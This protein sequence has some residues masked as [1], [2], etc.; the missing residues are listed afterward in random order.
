MESP[1]LDIVT[2][3]ERCY[4]LL[5][6]HIVSISS[7]SLAAMDKLPLDEAEGIEVHR[8]LQV[9]GRLAAVAQE[10]GAVF[11]GLT[12]DGQIVPEARWQRAEWTLLPVGSYTSGLLQGEFAVMA[13]MDQ[14]GFDLVRPRTRRVD[15][16]HLMRRRESA[17]TKT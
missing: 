14:T 6:D 10:G 12:E 1:V 9:A 8:L 4:V 17:V 5:A 11:F 16:E 3:G 13:R 2:A 15:A 7:W